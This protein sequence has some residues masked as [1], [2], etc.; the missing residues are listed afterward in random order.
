MAEEIV[1]LVGDRV[2]Y[3]AIAGD[4]YDAVVSAVIESGH[5]WLDVIVP[6]CQ[7]GLRVRAKRH[8]SAWS[9]DGT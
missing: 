2:R 1:T 7:D 8:G 6:G 3:R 9:K 4:T 5:A